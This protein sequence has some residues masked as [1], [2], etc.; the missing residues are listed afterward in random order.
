MFVWEKEQNL[1]LKVLRNIFL[2]KP[3]YILKYCKA[4]I[5]LGIFV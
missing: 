1:S 2:G 3:I 4:F 5:M